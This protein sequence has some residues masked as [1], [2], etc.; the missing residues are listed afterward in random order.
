MILNKISYMSQNAIN[1]MNVDSCILDASC[2]LKEL[3]E[4]SIDAGASEITIKIEKEGLQLIQ[5][6]DNGKGMSP[7]DMLL[8]IEKHTSS[9]ND[10]KDELEKSKSLGF[11]GLALQQ[12][13]KLGQTE[14]TSRQKNRSRGSYLRLSDGKY[15]P[16]KECYSEIGTKIIIRNLFYNSQSHKETS[17]SGKQE[18][19]KILKIINRYAIGYPFIGFKTYID[20][21]KYFIFEKESKETINPLLSRIKKIHG[22]KISEDLIY[23]NGE[24]GETTFNLFY[25]NK[26]NLFKTERNQSYYINKRPFFNEKIQKILNK[27]YSDTFSTSQYPAFFLFISLP[28]SEINYRLDPSKFNIHF[29]NEKETLEKLTSFLDEAFHG[30]QKINK[31]DEKKKIILNGS[32][33]NFHKNFILEQ[34]NSGI[35]ITNTEKNKKIEIRIESLTKL[36][37]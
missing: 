10:E 24:K 37:E 28:N 31:N 21:K 27:T 17:K 8:S 36:F 3:I 1:L 14:I 30:N 11:R 5:I 22:K 16:V 26:Q 25:S 29:H 12:I 2:V 32:F 9:I 6:V 15:E 23:Y 4:N 20:G 35:S 34:T 18:L 7:Q 13:C 19:T 33:V